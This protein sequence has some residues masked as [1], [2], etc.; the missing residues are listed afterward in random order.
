MIFFLVI[1]G[2]IDFL[3]WIFS[4][5]TRPLSKDWPYF[6]LGLFLFTLL[7]EVTLMLLKAH[8][9]RKYYRKQLEGNI[10]EDRQK[11][12]RK[13][14]NST[15]KELL[16]TIADGLHQGQS[17]REINKY[18]KQVSDNY[19]S[20]A[21]RK[22]GNSKRYNLILFK[23]PPKAIKTSTWIWFTKNTA[24][25][26]KIAEDK[27]DND[28]AKYLENGR[29]RKLLTSVLYALAWKSMNSINDQLR[30]CS[31][32]PHPDRLIQVT[33]VYK[34][35]DYGVL[36]ELQLFDNDKVLATLEIYKEGFVS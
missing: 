32:V 25:L 5:P 6:W 2:V 17:L 8:S 4:K 18:L 35:G 7:F 13:D 11:A 1:R 34:S 14:S 15:E 31:W 23:H 21:L 26:K 36:M 22:R 27:I 24:R 16:F 33:P 19:F 30:H 3:L 10:N 28:L 29:G 9:V 12:V 20:V